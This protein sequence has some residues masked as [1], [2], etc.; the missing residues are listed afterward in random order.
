MEP[1]REPVSINGDGDAILYTPDSG[2]GGTTDTFT[3]TI[4]D[5]NGGSATATVTVDIDDLTRSFFEGMVYSDVDQN[6]QQDSGEDG[7]GGVTVILEGTDISNQEVRMEAVSALDGSYR[8][9]GIAPG[10]YT[11]T[12][13]Q[14]EFLNSLP[15][16]FGLT[17]TDDDMFEFQVSED[18][19]ASTNNTFTE[20]GLPPQFAMINA[21]SSARGPNLFVIMEGD[22]LAWLDENGGW[23]S[24]GTLGLSLNGDDL[25]IETE[26]GT[27]SIS[28]ANRDVVQLIGR[29]GDFTLLRIMG[30]SEDV[31]SAAAIDAVMAG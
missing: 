18:L 1:P 20:S 5:G 26:D 2:A 21:L 28:M 19:I 7:L 3:Y 17:V 23:D 4:S 22:E 14:P 15:N 27:G 10:D 16:T 31:L 25:M 11:I 6:G 29:R 8:F 30:S 13:M 9:E 12:E 24:V